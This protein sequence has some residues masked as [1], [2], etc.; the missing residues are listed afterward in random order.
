MIFCPNFGRKA[1][2]ILKEMESDT[3][4][5]IC[6]PIDSGLGIPHGEGKITRIGD[7]GNVYYVTLRCL[8]KGVK[9]PVTEPWTISVK[10]PTLFLVLNYP[11]EQKGAKRKNQVFP[12][13]DD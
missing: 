8:V 7:Q 11:E 2:G 12:W 9:D 10:S 1:N 3:L 4:A 6:T 13:C 5:R